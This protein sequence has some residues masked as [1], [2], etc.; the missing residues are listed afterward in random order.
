MPTS[1][2]LYKA[3][4]A[5]GFSE[6]EPNA[7]M[8]H[9]GSDLYLKCGPKL[10]ELL[11]LYNAATGRHNGISFVGTDEQWWKEFPFDYTPFWDRDEQ[12]QEAVRLWR[13]PKNKERADQIAEKVK[14]ERQ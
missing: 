10:D 14:N 5:A 11:L 2:D 3:A 12:K 6:T 9:H 7:T 13:K 1:F 8:G 4:L